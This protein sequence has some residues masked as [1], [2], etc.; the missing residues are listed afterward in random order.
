MAAAWATAREISEQLIIIL[1]ERRERTEA[2]GARGPGERDLAD[3]H[4]LGEELARRSESGNDLDDSG[5][6]S[7]LHGEASKEEGL[8]G[9]QLA[10][11]CGEMGNDVRRGETS[12]TT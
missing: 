1:Q 3:L 4:V 2:T 7:R 12:R 5:R 9:S 11:R 8:R 6:E 10:K